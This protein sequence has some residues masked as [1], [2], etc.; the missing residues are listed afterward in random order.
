[1]FEVLTFEKKIFP[2]T[3]GKT[4]CEN[5]TYEHDQLPVNTVENFFS[6]IESITAPAVEELI[7]VIGNVKNGTTEIE[8]FKDNSGQIK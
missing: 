1:M 3:I 6:R 5:Y 4:M 2:T 8:D 7:E